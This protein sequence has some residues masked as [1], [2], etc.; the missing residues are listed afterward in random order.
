MTRKSAG[1]DAVP[2]FVGALVAAAALCLPFAATTAVGSGS[3]YKTFSL[4]NS[5][6]RSAALGVVVAVVVAVLL[7][8]L[9][10]P[11]LG[12][13][14]ATVATAVLAIDYALASAA[15][16]AD[17]LTSL[18]YIDAL[19]GGVILGALGVGALRAK[20]SALGYAF[21]VVLAALYAEL[22]VAMAP[23]EVA[24]SR[25]IAV[26][27]WLILLALVLLAAATWHRRHGITLQRESSQ[28]IDLPFG[29]LV[30]AAL[31]AATLLLTA[32]WTAHHYRNDGS[33]LGYLIL[34]IVVSEVC[35]LI[36]ALM[37]PGRDGIVLMIATSIAVS[38]DA[39]GYAPRLGWG[40][41][42]VA[43]LVVAGFALGIRWAVPWFGFAGFAV[44]CVLAV[45]AAHWSSSLLWSLGIGAIACSAG[46]AFGSV[47]VGYLPAGI[48]S[49]G[50]LLLPS[51]VWAIPTESSD[52]SP[53]GAVATSTTPGFVALAMTLCATASAVLL[54]RIRPGDTD[55]PPDL[56]VDDPRDDEPEDDASIR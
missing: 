15:D 18:N 24:G 33:G 16:T 29:P 5:V 27:G 7:N 52:W 20:A 39:L 34:L 22:G 55:P 14:T 56:L 17:V 48:L 36:A 53:G 37:L 31:M 8:T 10:R 21:G 32:E 47:R 42:V 50:C 45:L 13:L 49:L 1:I 12:W 25:F 3:A 4:V 19:C 54:W 40:V 51:L 46:F 28:A 35:F 26:P 2:A 6:P 11:A 43:A 41:P 23:E 30:A 38:A 44:T 9:R